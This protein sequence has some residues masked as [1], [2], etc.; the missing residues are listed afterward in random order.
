MAQRGWCA[1]ST[2]SYW[3]SLERPKENAKVH[4]ER[5]MKKNLWGTK[6]KRERHVK[7]IKGR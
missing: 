1:G 6:L 4:R 2:A 3:P 5:E 7:D